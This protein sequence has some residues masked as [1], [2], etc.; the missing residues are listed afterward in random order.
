VLFVNA[1]SEI[2][3]A[4]VDLLE[5]CRHL[6]RRRF[7]PVVVLPREGPLSDEFR[8]AGVRLLRLDAA[9]VKRFGARLSL[10][11]YPLRFGHAAL[12][13]R[14]LLQFE[15]PALVHVNTSLLPAASLAASLARV[16]YVWHVRELSP[17]QGPRIV[18]DA[19]RWCIRT[20]PSG[21]VAISQATAREIGGDTRPTANRVSVIPHGVDVERFRPSPPHIELRREIGIP[22]GARVVGYLGRLAPIKGLPHLID[23]FA[24][25]AQDRTDAHLLIVGPTLSYERHLVALRK[26]AEQHGLSER[27]HFVPGTR[28]P[29]EFLRAMDLVVLPTVIPEGLGLVILEALAAG[30]PVVA[31]NQGG[32]VEI[33]AG[34]PFGRLVPPR[35][36]D[37]LAGAIADFLDLP[38]DRRAALASA[39][40]DYAVDRFSMR[41]MI[42][43]LSRVYDRILA[44]G[45]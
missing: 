34:R 3:G 8:R 23:A 22:E 26:Q 17:L 45:S 9:P 18:S 5:I 1:T 41:R 27:V 21:V 35:D 38:P 24:L 36:T 43:Q 20:W 11:T 19:L 25:L 37:G 13:L 6:D 42:D 14:R 4:D 29:E 15:R 30:K 39:A 28:R 2:G 7:D 33:L 32:P 12:A 31:T 10:A 44:S 40:R 16:P